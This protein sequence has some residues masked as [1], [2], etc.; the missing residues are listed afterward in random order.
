M[1]LGL[2]QLGQGTVTMGSFG[3]TLG[4]LNQTSSLSSSLPISSTAASTVYQAHYGLNSLGKLHSIGIEIVSSNT[5]QIRSTT[6]KVNGK[7]GLFNQLE[8]GMCISVANHRV[9]V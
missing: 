4:Q 2:S 8:P 9:R 6:N 3:Q 5:V 1:I 7:I